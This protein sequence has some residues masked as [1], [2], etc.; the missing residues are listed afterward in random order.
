[1]PRT[2]KL[3]QKNDENIDPDIYESLKKTSDEIQKYKYNLNTDLESL[4]SLTVSNNYN[5]ANTYNGNGHGTSL[6]K[7]YKKLD[8]LSSASID[9]GISQIDAIK[10]SPVL[11]ANEAAF[12]AK[13]VSPKLAS[14]PGHGTFHHNNSSDFSATAHYGNHSVNSSFTSLPSTNGYAL[15]DTLISNFNANSLDVDS[16]QHNL[17]GI[18][19][20]VQESSPTEVASKFKDIYKSLL[21]KF[22]SESGTQVKVTILQAI[23]QIVHKCP[24]EEYM[25]PT[26]LR[27]LEASKDSEFAKAAEEASSFAMASYDAVQCFH[28]LKPYINSSESAQSIAAIKMLTKVR[29]CWP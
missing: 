26:V 11:L 5:S 27:L 9:S 6:H 22:A 28:L 8:H 10:N 17:L 20:L 14:A 21:S 25:E 3:S 2:R 7:P 29:R 24:F 16:Y 15:N 4:N 18:I 12:V 13:A 19:Q 1:M 23:G